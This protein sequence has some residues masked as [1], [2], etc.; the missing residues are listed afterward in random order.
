VYQHHT[1]IWVLGMSHMPISCVSDKHGKG[2]TEGSHVIVMKE[3]GVC[4]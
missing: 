2:R 3:M 1:R 4:K